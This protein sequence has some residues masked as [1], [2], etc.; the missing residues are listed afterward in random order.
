MMEIKQAAHKPPHNNPRP[1][2]RNRKISGTLL[3]VNCLALLKQALQKD[4]QAQRGLVVMVDGVG[5]DRV[6]QG[7]LVGDLVLTYMI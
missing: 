5:I 3:W 6:G 4:H 2:H 1:G 7:D